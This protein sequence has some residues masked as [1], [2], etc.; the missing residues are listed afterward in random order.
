MV[1]RPQGATSSDGS[2]ASIAAAGAGTATAAATTPSSWGAVTA[3]IILTFRLILITIVV[4]VVL[5]L[6]DLSV[7]WVV[8][9]AVAVALI[10]PALLLPGLVHALAG[11][12]SVDAPA[13]G[14][15]A[16]GYRRRQ[17]L[18]RIERSFPEIL[19]ERLF[20]NYSVVIPPD[21][22]SHPIS[23]VT[24]RSLRRERVGFNTPN[25][26]H[27]NSYDSRNQENGTS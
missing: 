22:L 1:R 24:H 17:A 26:H 3:N 16:G 8:G 12:R 19:A 9:P 13:D 14:G 21:R 5:T 18:S 15:R 11:D 10:G 27:D 2:S 20:G 7:W 6:P 25:S 23:T 4:S